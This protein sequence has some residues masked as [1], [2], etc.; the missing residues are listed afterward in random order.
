MATVSILNRK[1]AAVKST[2]PV[3]LAFFVSVFRKKAAVRCTAG[4]QGPNE[5]LQQAA[6]KEQ[7]RIG[8]VQKRGH[9]RAGDRIRKKG[10]VG[11]VADGNEKRHQH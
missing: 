6:N 2:F 3:F 1:Q 4:R 11:K 8:I 9:S 10:G 7:Q 5:V